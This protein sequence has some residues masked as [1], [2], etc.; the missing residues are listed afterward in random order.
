MSISIAARMLQ[1]MGLP[2]LL[3]QLMVC[4][5]LEVTVLY[6]Q[7]DAMGPLFVTAKLAIDHYGFSNQPSIDSEEACFPMRKREIYSKINLV[8]CSKENTGI[9]CLNTPFI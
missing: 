7:V 2:T 9:K 3:Y 6:R 8:Y 4:T 5:S 1:L